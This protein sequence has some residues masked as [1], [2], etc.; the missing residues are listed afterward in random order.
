MWGM[1]LW[2]MLLPTAY[3]VWQ[4]AWRD[5]FQALL[6]EEV[7]RQ[8]MY[9]AELHEIDTDMEILVEQEELG[10]LSD[11]GLC[12]NFKKRVWQ[13]QK[14]IARMEQYGVYLTDVERRMNHPLFGILVF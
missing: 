8:K 2:L 10:Y 3:I 6:A 1:G 9:Y 14:R 13:C 7:E 11:V 12:F 4:I 5:A